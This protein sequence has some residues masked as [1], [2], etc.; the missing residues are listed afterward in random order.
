MKRGNSAFSHANL[1][2]GDR[3]DE[4]Y[5]LKAW[6]RSVLKHPSPPDLTSGAQSS[7]SPGTEL[8]ALLR[9]Q[10]MQHF[11]SSGLVGT[12]AVERLNG[13]QGPSSAQRTQRCLSIFPTVAWTFDVGTQS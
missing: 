12:E 7:A 9:K 13:E 11:V 8:R 1:I 3:S 4:L 10:K 6:S 2:A 5:P